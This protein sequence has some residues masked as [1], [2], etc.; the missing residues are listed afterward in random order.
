MEWTQN[1]TIRLL[2]H[3]KLLGIT[4]NHRFSTHE[5]GWVAWK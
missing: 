1:A 5:Y 2:G 3:Q 4:S